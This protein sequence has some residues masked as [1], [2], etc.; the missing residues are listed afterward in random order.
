VRIAPSLDR[1]LC[2]DGKIA[3]ILWLA[4]PLSLADDLAFRTYL[5]AKWGVTA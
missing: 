1:I 3:E 4:E 5:A 2:S